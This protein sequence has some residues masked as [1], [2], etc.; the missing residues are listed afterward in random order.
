MQS[1][2][3][4]VLNYVSKR[5]GSTAFVQFFRIEDHE[6]ATQ[7]LYRGFWDVEWVHMAD[8]RE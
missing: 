4:T 7:V 2:H 5:A 1:A 6:D 3:E 8:R